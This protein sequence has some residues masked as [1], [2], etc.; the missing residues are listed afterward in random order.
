[1]KKVRNK[2]GN[3]C[4]KFSI[5]IKSGTGGYYDSDNCDLHVIDLESDSIPQQNEVINISKEGELI[6]RY[7]VRSVERHYN[8][9]KEDGNWQYGEFITIYVIPC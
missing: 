1:M 4:M 9:P 3:D 8:I 5:N 7:L 6:E 2:K